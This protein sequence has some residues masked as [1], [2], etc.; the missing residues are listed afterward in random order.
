[1]N[2]STTPAASR[3]LDI[4]D[5]VIVLKRPLPDAVGAALQIPFPRTAP[6]VVFDTH[7]GTFADGP[8]ATA[9]LKFVKA[10]RSGA[11]ILTTRPALPV[12]QHELD[13]HR[14]G[15]EPPPAINPHI[16]PEGTVSYSYE[17]PEDAL[18]LAF[19][20]TYQSKVLSKTV[21]SWGPAAKASVTR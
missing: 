2:A 19:S 12:G 16:P 14:F 11:L 7:E 15:A 9:E 17:F 10:H 20:F 3:V 21:L 4:V 18:T 8:F 5:A 1:M 6:G 13:L